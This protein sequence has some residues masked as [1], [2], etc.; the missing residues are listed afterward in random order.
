MITIAFAN[1]KGGVGKT[2][3]AV[4]LGHALAIYG[5]RTLIVDTDPQGHVAL[6]L[7]LDKAPMLYH[8]LVNDDPIQRCMVSARPNLWIVPG[9]KSTEKAKRYITSMDF[10]ENVISSRLESCAELFDVMLIDM[11]PSLDV[12]H[13]AALVACD[14]MI[15]P[16]RLDHLAVDGVNEVLRTFAEISFHH[17]N[18]VKGFSIIP[19]FYDRTTNETG[20]QLASLYRAYGNKVLPPIPVDTKAREAAAYGKTLYEYAP[21]S[22]ALIGY[23]HGSVHGSVGSYNQVID[24]MIPL[25]GILP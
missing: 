12:L 22:A 24:R 20:V 23:N 19:T 9:D 5:L 6:S 10:R 18:S 4:T 2:T 8:W 7:C 3:T 25:L 15:V 11:A 1:Q 14:W 16:T 21:N 13:I 17:G